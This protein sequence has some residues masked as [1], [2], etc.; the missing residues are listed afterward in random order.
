[1]ATSIYVGN[2]SYDSN[3]QGIRQLFEQYGQV[4]TVKLIEDRDTGRP[5]G[6]GFVEMDAE[7]ADSAI[8]ALDGQSLDGRALKVN[9][10]KPREPRPSR[11]W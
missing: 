1:M 6:F 4:H 5:R 7:E 3:E 8:R 10:A 9:L 2:L 11:S